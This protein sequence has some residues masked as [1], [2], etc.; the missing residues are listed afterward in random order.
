MRRYLYIRI[1]INFF[2]FTLILFLISCGTPD[3][4]KKTAI[5]SL[6][7]SNT[8]AANTNSP[9]GEIAP[10]L[11]GF[12]VNKIC[13]LPT[14]ISG[15][16]PFGALGGGKWE[17]WGDSESGLN[18]GCIGGN[19]SVKLEQEAA[20]IS[21]RYDVMGDANAAHYVSAKY[22]ALQY[23]GRPPAES[24]LRRGYIDFCDN[25]SKSFY[26]RPLPEKFR[27][28]LMD[29]SKYSNSETPNNYHEK[30]GEG[31]VNLAARRE[32]ELMVAVEV[33]FFFSEA[34][35]KKYKDS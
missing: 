27:K 22:T 28:R 16:S 9:A 11:H 13:S 33:R 2:S 14:E 8:L 21:A 30:V 24:S 3:S 1:S 6:S 5:P 10:E 17:K 18:Y 19:D 31:Y 4:A 23:G 20:K 15:N 35:Y 25:L 29:E 32:G 12:S 26:G 7:N 34:E